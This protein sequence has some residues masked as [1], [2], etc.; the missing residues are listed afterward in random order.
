LVHDDDDDDDENVLKKIN[1]FIYIY[2]YIL[3]LN[4]QLKKN[5]L[6]AH[7]TNHAKIRDSEIL[8]IFKI[9]FFK[10]DKPLLFLF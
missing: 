5:N 4:G 9:L 3:S 10:K 1:C 8:F 7:T 2:I 6:I